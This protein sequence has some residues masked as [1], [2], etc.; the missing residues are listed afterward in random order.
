M[1]VLQQDPIALFHSLSDHLLS[2]LFLSLTQTLVHEFEILVLVS[3][4]RLGE[5]EQLLC[6]VDTLAQYENYRRELVTVSEKRLERRNRRSGKLWTDLV[7]QI[8]LYSVGQ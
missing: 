3:A 7:G 2:Y 5:G 6:R 4:L 8:F 1:T